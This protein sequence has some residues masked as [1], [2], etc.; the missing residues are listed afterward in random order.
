MID[1]VRHGARQIAATLLCSLLATI[2]SQAL[3][4]HGLASHDSACLTALE[5]AHDESS[6]RLSAPLTTSERHPLHCL[7]CH[8]ARTF[9]PSPQID[10][11][12][13]P[14]LEP[15]AAVHVVSAPAPRAV[16]A[17]PLSLR[18]PPSSID[19]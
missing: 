8:L 10:R 11:Q 4:A 7:V 18:A 13:A 15:R 12:S 3:P 6:H 17:A 19:L 1:L 9:R 5:L 14:D 2:V 16:D